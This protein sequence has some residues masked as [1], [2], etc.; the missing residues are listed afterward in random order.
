MRKQLLIVLASAGVICLGEKAAVAQSAYF[1][2]VTN[3]NPV[4][5]M[6]LQETAQP[7]TA[8]VETNLGSLGRVADAIYS[9]HNM[10]KGAGGATS[11]GDFSASDSDA[12]GGFCAVPTTDPRTTIQSSKFTVEVWVNPAETGRNF[13]GIV[14]K[15]GGNTAGIAGSNNQGGFCLS[16]NY[17]AYLDNANM[18]GF[19]FHVYNGVGH[20]GAEAVVPLNVQ[21]NQWYHLVGV[22][23]GTNCWLYVN[24]TNMTAAGVGYQ[25]PMT[26]SYVPDFWSQLMIGS[27]RNLNG[28]NYHGL[29]DEV[30]IYTNALSQAQ[31]QAHYNAAT[32]A[33][34]ASTILGDHP[35]MYYRMDSPSYT[36]PDPGSYPQAATYGVYSNSFGAMYGT[37]SQPGVSGP[38]FSGMQDP[39][40]GNA[41]YGVAI[42][43][44]GGNNGASANVPVGYDFSGNPQ[45]AADAAPIIVTNLSYTDP[46]EPVLNPT[47]HTPFSVTIWFKA[48][49]HDWSRFQTLFGHSDQGWRMSM[50]TSGVIQWNPGPGGETS[51]PYK[52]DD[53][54]WHQFLGTYDGTNVLTYVDGVLVQ[55]ATTTSVNAGSHLFPIIGGDPFYLDSGNAY[56]AGNGGTGNTTYRNRSFSGRLAH[57]AFFTNVLSGTQVQNLYAAANPNQAPYI[58]AQPTSGR[59]NPAPAFLFFG[60]V[61]GGSAPLSYQWYFNN[62]S[63]NY[64]GATQLANDGA[65]YILV[66][67]SQMTVSNLQPS[68][69]GYYFVVV[70]NNFGAVT[71]QLASLTVNY[72]PV[73]TA[74]NPAANFSLYASQT[75]ALSVTTATTT[76]F[77]LTYYWYTNNVL[78]PT[79]STATYNLG[80]VTA[81]QSGETFRT[82]VS[83]AVGT[84]SSTTVTL[85]VNP[86]PTSLTSSSFSSGVLAMKPTAYW[87]M[88]E[89]GQAPA[90]ASVETNLGSWGQANNGYYDD[91]RQSVSGGAGNLL[92]NSGI[93]NNEWSLHNFP[94]AIAGDGDTAV[95]FSGANRTYV[96]VPRV[97]PT[98]SGT[99]PAATTL[100]P[101]F[102]LEAWVKP[103]NNRSFGIM[104]GEDSGGL[105]RNTARAGF[106]WLY[107]GTANTFSITVYNGNGGGSTE[108]KTTAVYPPGVWYHVVTTFDGT[109]IAYYINGVQDPLQNSSAATLNPNTYDPI[110]IGC[111]RGLNANVFQGGIDEVAVYTNLLPLAEIQKHYNDGTNAAFANYEGDVLADSPV[112]YYRM[113][114]PPYVAPATTT[115]PVLTNY[116]A[117]GVNGVYTPGSVPGTG[118]APSEDGAAI[119]GLPV[120]NSFQA[121]GCS[122]FAD[123]GFVPQFSP[124]G[125]TPFTVAAWVKGNPADISRGWQGI[126]AKGDGSWRM[127]IDGNGIGTGGSGNANFNS[128]PGN[129]VDIGNGTSPLIANDGAWHYVVG[130][131][132][133]TNSFVYMDGILSAKTGNTSAQSITAQSSEVFLAAYP[134]NAVYANTPTSVANEIGRVL[135]GSMC[136]AAF[137]NGVALSTN[138]INTLFAAAQVPPVIDLQPASG[139]ANQNGGFTNTF[140]ASGSGPLAYQWY[141]NGAPRANQTN[142]N[143]VLSN[144]QQ[145]DA[146]A[147][148]YVVV[149]NNYG[150]VTSSVWSLTVNSVPTITQDLANTNFVV[151]AGAH[152]NFT[153]AAS[154]A[155]P[156]HY[157]WYS[158]NVA[159]STATSATYNL[160]NVQPAGA[161]NTYYC[162][163]TN[164]AGT[165]NS[166]TAVVAIVTVPTAIPYSTVILGDNPVGFWPLNEAEVGSGDNGVIANDYWSGFNGIYTNVTLGQPGFNPTLAPNDTAV[167]VGLLAFSD[168]D[169]FNIPTNV[170]FSTTNTPSTFSVEAWVKGFQQTVD[171]GIVSK[172]F[173]GGGEQFNLDCGSGSGS[174]AHSFRFFVRDASGTV[175]PI[176]STVNPGDTLWHHL[177]GVCDE[178][179]TVVTLYIDGLPV[180]S[181]P[182]PKNAGIL[183]SPRSMLIGSRPS[184]STTNANDFNFVGTIQD[185]A[186]YNYALTAQQVVN[187][188]NAGD[189]PASVVKPPTN[190]ITGELG[191]AVF[192]PVIIGTPPISYQWFQNG[193]PLANATNATLVLSNVPAGDNGF[194][195]HIHVSNAFGSADSTPEATLTVISGAPQIFADVP[196]AAFALK[197]GSFSI[198][199]TA[200]GTEPL[201]YQWQAAD[202]NT[203]AWTNLSD[204]GRVIGT[205]SNI[206]SI[207]SAQKTDAGAYRVVVS[208]G[209]GSVN[210]GVTVV[211]IGTLPINFNGNGVGWTTN[212]SATIVNGLLTLT[213]GGNGGNGSFYF[214]YPQYIG[215][216]KASFTYKAVGGAD[217]TVFVVQ[218][219]PRGTAALGGGG[220]SLGVS[221]VTPSWD[222]ELN[223]YTGNTEI[224]GY[225]ILTNGL[226]GAGGANGN[227][228]TPG[229]VNIGSGDPI[230]VTLNYAAGQVSITFTD[231]VAGTF[232]VTN[233]TVGSIPNIVGSSSAYVGFSGAMGGVTSVQTITNF[234]FISIPLQTIQVA[235]PNITI[236]WPGSVVGYV[237]QQNTSLTNPAGWVN[238]A[239]PD[240]IVNG[241]H[242]VVVPI[243]SGTGFYRLNL[244]P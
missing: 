158:N 217:G 218:N 191:T 151:Y 197:G 54:S 111:G 238:V 201:T 37:A 177:V 131:F 104:V 224:Q 107:S 227:Y 64:A 29:I 44:I 91:W 143:L 4:I 169:V 97:S 119:G 181:T 126:V 85:T 70:S 96:V 72:T 171:A 69:S 159:L 48:N 225:T 203:L 223:L 229:S 80:P 196:P 34:Y 102:T 112:L 79:A 100:K 175:Y 74:Q 200:Y 82:V 188:Y 186:V 195:Y 236:S 33:T 241:Q 234:S 115:W 173:G 147:N 11:D 46:A 163:V 232:F 77:P 207:S 49:P 45:L 230:D 235:A 12:W 93:T 137:W 47:N 9:G 62:S 92:G 132:D 10:A 106:D 40:N 149:T 57:F 228:I 1:E 194:T 116:G 239:N 192:T 134:N 27:S 88:H 183:S 233:R 122:T 94:G 213:D 165:I 20:G 66:N 145:S 162:T 161:T 7:P 150:S 141:V 5:Y 210:S 164:S 39:N 123:A 78:D 226:T 139:S 185:V 152:I 38:P 190:A 105:N 136:E 178:S 133:G 67:T 193:S 221:G 89:V 148:W 129:N 101:P 63:S 240:N 153:I 56:A 84:A 113:D 75:F 22:F 14:S 204:N 43:G 180:G 30:A 52:Y 242:Q 32:G 73:I 170:D 138:Q 117:I 59:V 83:N 81:A 174:I 187:H 140:L 25:L 211:I 208:N 167:S 128:G 135:A 26:G 144:V 60:T 216:F 51:T 127:A 50:N 109:N 124:S 179:N 18:I 16:E 244:Q 198:P 155:V 24:G 36:A 86:L 21:A 17:L 157:Q 166:R 35:Y 98:V 95:Q 118:P 120:A 202:T 110:T 176:N 76:N 58:L 90:P 172:G 6:P 42:N 87:P 215:A 99:T 206:L 156:L 65:K 23:D 13:E 61:A 160:A 53:G 2:A 31:V 184:S 125:S 220:G 199:V 209:S 189:I 168:S 243:T 142:A 55:T 222:F 41:S 71:S 19:D 68:D 146:S 8:D 231:A 108:P 28:N 103:S 130:T 15:T 219:D 154:G 237:L 214:A 121:N 212:G 205:T 114:A 3:L 182:I